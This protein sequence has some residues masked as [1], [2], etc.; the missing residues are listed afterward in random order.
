MASAQRIEQYV[1]G[2]R[3]QLKQQQHVSLFSLDTEI[4]QA[5]DALEVRYKES[6]ISLSLDL[7]ESAVLFGD[8]IKFFRLIAN[9]L[10][11]AIE[12]CAGSG[13]SRNNQKI[14][15]ILVKK[16][17]EYI[18]TIEDTGQGI[19]KDDLS[20]IFDPF[21]TT[22]QTSQNTG[23][24]LSISKE[25]VEQNFGGTISVESKQGKGAKV[26]IILPESNDTA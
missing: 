25:I 26:I 18:L 7:E 13:M 9:L 4:R 23:I 11:N 6:N 1:M 20:D 22:K 3:A 15:V 24:G 19:R 12:A 14:T 16:A 8:R 5:T 17:S 10:G 2:A 21:F